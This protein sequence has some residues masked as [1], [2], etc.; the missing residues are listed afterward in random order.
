MQKTTLSERNGLYTMDEIVIKVNG[1]TREEYMEACHLSARRLYVMLAVVMAIIC[2][3]II[4]ATGNASWQAF[5]GP[6]LVY[7]ICVGGYEAMIRKNYKGQLEQV[8]EVTYTITKLGW[9]CKV[10]DQENYIY[11][12]GTPRMAQ[13]K[14]GVFLY[15]D[16][17]N[18]SLLPRRLLTQEQIDQLRQWFK[19]SRVLAK[20]FMQNEARK[21]R[22]E[23]QER[24]RQNRNKARGPAWGPRKRR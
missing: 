22:K 2:G 3:V 19:E 7:V 10:G 4:L 13:T 8:E 12:K 9:T 24:H 1:V 17:V 16:E 14:H 11:W 18:S 15:C 21:Q 6:L 23:D 20:E 5:F